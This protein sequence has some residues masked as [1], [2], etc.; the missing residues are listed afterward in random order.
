[1]S[2]LP[3]S[4]LTAPGAI[5]SCIDAFDTYVWAIRLT[6]GRPQADRVIVEV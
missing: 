2:A 5:E 4:T 3:L 6:T 1:M